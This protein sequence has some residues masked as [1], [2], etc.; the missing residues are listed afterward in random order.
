MEYALNVEQR[1]FISRFLAVSIGSKAL[2]KKHNLA[3]NYS[4]PAPHID[5]LETSLEVNLLFTL[6]KR[7]QAFMVQKSQALLS[8]YVDIGLLDVNS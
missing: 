7:P 3:R 6:K 5:K 8:G 2:Q 1:Q 4:A